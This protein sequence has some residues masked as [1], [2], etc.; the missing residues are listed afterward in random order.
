MELF[1]LNLRFY[2]GWP[3]RTA[4]PGVPREVT[5]VETPL[6][7]AAVSSDRSTSHGSVKQEVAGHLF[8]PAG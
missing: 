6:A 5:P 3:S 8:H 1:E 4:L 2:V 7:A